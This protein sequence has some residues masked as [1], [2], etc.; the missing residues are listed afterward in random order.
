[1]TISIIPATVNH[2]D[3][4][5]ACLAD[6]DIQRFYFS[7]AEY[8]KKVIKNGIGKNELFVAV[9]PDQE[10]LGFYWADPRGMFCSFP[11]LR[12]LS[13]H[14]CHRSAGIGAILL[15]HFESTGFA[16]ATKLFLAVSDFNT[17]AQAFYKRNGYVK[18]GEV[19]DL[20]KPGIAE[21][22][23]MKTKSVA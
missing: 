6:S 8:A 3:M 10:V 4:C 9:N 17:K 18:I 1:M 11:Y 15:A 20:Y 12:L 14:P 22:I 19:P 23:M 5:S 13:V 21:Q 7:D 2:I 16:N